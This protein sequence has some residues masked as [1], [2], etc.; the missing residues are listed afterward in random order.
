MTL[1]KKAETSYINTEGNLVFTSAYLKNKG[2]CCK[3][4]CLHCPFGFTIKKLGIQFRE[5]APEETTLLEGYL[6]LAPAP[7][8][9]STFPTEHRQWILLKNTIAGVILKNHIVVKHMILGE[10]FKNQGIEKDL[11]ESYYFC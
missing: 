10:H 2:T 7:I 5:V 3:S 1:E 9:L 6:A 11:V 8:D 4:A